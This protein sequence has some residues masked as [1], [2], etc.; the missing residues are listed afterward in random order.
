MVTINM[1]KLV[2]K[3]SVKRMLDVKEGIRLRCF[4]PM[5]I[6]EGVDVYPKPI[7]CGR[8]EDD[9]MRY[10]CP[11]CFGDLEYTSASWYPSSFYAGIYECLNC[12]YVYA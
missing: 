7:K 8:E 6:C 11:K 4:P 10:E 9:R 1:E 2:V 3:E 5:N 12:T